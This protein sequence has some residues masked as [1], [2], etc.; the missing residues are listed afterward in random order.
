M[1]L[2]ESLGLLLGEFCHFEVGDRETGLLDHI[3]DL[4]D[5]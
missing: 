4:A 5:M 1:A 2:A 3:D